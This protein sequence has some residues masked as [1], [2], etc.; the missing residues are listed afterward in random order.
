MFSFLYVFLCGTRRNIC[1]DIVVS[2]LCILLF[3]LLILLTSSIYRVMRGGYSFPSLRGRGLPGLLFPT[4]GRLLLLTISEWG[5]NSH[6]TCFLTDPQY[7][8]RGCM[9]L[10][11]LESWVELGATRFLRWIGRIFAWAKVY[12]PV[13]YLYWLEFLSIEHSFYV[14]QIGVY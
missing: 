9:I 8:D 3:F 12:S 1:Y 7:S 2:I 14:N 5:N 4:W 13:T 10:S 6:A 11:F